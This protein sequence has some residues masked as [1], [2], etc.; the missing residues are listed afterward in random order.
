MKKI[1][2]VILAVILCF[3]LAVSALAGDYTAPEAKEITLDGVVTEEEWGAPIFKGV[4][5]INAT[6]GS[7]DG[8]FDFWFFD[9]TYAG[10][11]NF[12]LYVNNDSENIY[13]GVI[14][15]E[16]EID[17]TSMG[18]NLWQHQN[19]T[20]TIATSEGSGVPSVDIGGE[21]HEQYTGFR[22]A[23]KANGSPI[24]EVMT[25]G[26]DATPL[27]DDQYRIVYDEANGTITYEVAIPYS[28]TNIDISK[29]TAMAF[30][31]VLPLKYASNSVDAGVNGANRFL[32]GRAAAFCGGPGNFAHTGQTIVINLNGPDAV[33]GIKGKVTEAP[34][35]EPS[36][37][38]TA[39]G[40]TPVETPVEGESTTTGTTVVEKVEREVVL[41]AT[42]QLY[43]II[44][45]G[46]VILID[47]VIILICL[48]KKRAPKKSKETIPEE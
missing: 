25:Q 31:A 46:V 5:P 26:L 43:I 9:N 19:F 10:S 27:T 14:M 30:S 21:M 11:E 7:V 16:T 36:A 45:S 33:A 4:T 47:T 41:K 44:I 1:I 35:E 8:L 28:L 6:N 2:T 34:I 37:E 24:C 12:D 18:A 42:H 40:E 32:V 38:E 23:M 39:P 13:L 29:S 3:A 22:I 48:L 17:S 15:H 20:F